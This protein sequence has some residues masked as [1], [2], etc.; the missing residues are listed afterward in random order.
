MGDKITILHERL[1]V[2]TAVS[3]AKVGARI[4][5]SDR[6]VKSFGLEEF[7]EMDQPDVKVG[8]RFMET[9]YFREKDGGKDHCWSLKVIRTK[10]NERVAFA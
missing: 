10:P 1:Y 6:M 5:T 4:E 7:S 8:V 2:V 9:E 3:G